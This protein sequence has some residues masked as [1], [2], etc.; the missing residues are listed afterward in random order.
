[1]RVGTI[2]FYP[3]LDKTEI[4]WNDDF[5]TSHIVTRLDALQD[6]SYI[7]ELMYDKTLKSEDKTE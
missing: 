1:M 2:Y 6:A 7:L 5:L 4:K 3:D